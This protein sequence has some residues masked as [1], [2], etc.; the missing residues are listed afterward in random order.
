MPILA[1]TL[2]RRR[3]VIDVHEHIPGLFDTRERLPKRLRP[4]AAWCVRRLLHLAE[5][6]CPITLAEPGYQALFRRPHPVFANY[7]DQLPAPVESDGS[8]VYVGDVTEARGL[9]DLAAAAERMEASP[10]I[11]IVGRC[12][13]QLAGRLSRIPNVE[14]LGR[15]P[16]SDA[17]EVVR[18]AAVGVSPLRDL[19]NYRYSLPTKVI[20]YLGVGI[21][22]VATDL[23]GTREVIGGRPGVRLVSPGDIAALAAALHAAV[24]DPEHRHLATANVEQTRTEFRWPHDSVVAFYNR[25]LS[26]THPDRPARSRSR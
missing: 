18:R 6:T 24:T 3:I 20:E 12:D 17:M 2:A 16:H 5:R 10:P 19:S 8:I 25:V 15:L 23:P 26:G 7:P 22:V 9:T 1:A 11:R 13:P 14:L 4:A 21:A